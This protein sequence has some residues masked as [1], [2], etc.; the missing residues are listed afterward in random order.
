MLKEQIIH[1]RAIV[2]TM[3]ISLPGTA[4]CM[5]VAAE[6]PKAATKA[7]RSLAPTPMVNSVAPVSTKSQQANNNLV[8][9]K[10]AIAKSDA[11]PITTNIKKKD[12]VK[13]K[14]KET[15]LDKI[16]NKGVRE[17]ISTIDEALLDNKFNKFTLYL[18]K[19][20]LEGKLLYFSHGGTIDKFVKAIKPLES[21]YREKSEKA[22]VYLLAANYF[23]KAKSFLNAKIYGLKEISLNKKETLGKAELI[24][25]ISM[26]KS[27]DYDGAKQHVFRHNMLVD[28]DSKDFYLGIALLAEINFHQNEFKSSAKRFNR[29][30]FKFP[31]I[32]YNN[33]GLYGTY[34]SLLKLND[35][36]SMLKEVNRYL[37]MYL[38][39]DESCNIR[40]IRADIHSA[41]GN[42]QMAESEYSSISKKHPYERCGKL[43]F[44]R[45][46]HLLAIKNNNL[47]SVASIKRL[48]NENQLTS[49]EDEGFYYLADILSKTSV[50]YLDT[51]AEYLVPPILNKNVSL[52]SAEK[53]MSETL[54]SMIKKDYGDGKFW[55]PIKKWNKYNKLASKDKNRISAGK[56]IISS[57]L[58]L[59]LPKEAL[60]VAKDIAADAPVGVLDSSIVSLKYLSGEINEDVAMKLIDKNRKNDG[61][62]SDILFGLAKGNDE[63]PEKAAAYLRSI[64]VSKRDHKYWV[65]RTKT[66]Y[67]LEAYNDALISAKKSDASWRILTDILM[68]LKSFN[69]MYEE[70]NSVSKKDHDDE[71]NFKM[72]IIMINKNNDN[73]AI[74]YLKKT[75][76]SETSIYRRAA[77]IAIDTI[78]LGAV[79]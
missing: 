79:K 28:T 75:I 57:Y 35:S 46:H 18:E 4:F 77:K 56:L 63:R 21:N 34:I 17:A 54:L 25:A 53:L 62:I 29:V 23:L 2:F 24:V 26:M 71:W 68:K 48:M 61:F 42:T 51:I 74:F 33:I 55:D 1:Y 43:A 66:S 31:D 32:V 44:L 22:G 52:H 11:L 72:G 76:G 27:G 78:K 50:G 36:P 73:Q 49:I 64:P 67:E 58:Q 15:I 69:S 70:L 65:L 59:E 9:Y 40:L 10:E 39:R 5:D 30:L 45:K 8:E 37:S 20:K 14:K 7:T 3:L 12:T 41:N 38:L 47:D 6:P 19:A 13:S 16:K 60:S